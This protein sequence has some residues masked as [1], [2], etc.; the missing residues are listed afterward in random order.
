MCKIC[1]SSS[2]ISN[3]WFCLQALED[4]THLLTFRAHIRISWFSKISE[5]IDIQSVVLCLWHTRGWGW[6]QCNRS[7]VQCMQIHVFHTRPLLSPHRPYCF[8]LWTSPKP[9]LLPPLSYSSTAHLFSKSIPF[10]KEKGVPGNTS[11]ENMEKILGSRWC[12]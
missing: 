1:P 5:I 3:V 9:N 11:S 10:W 4:W 12:Q 7:S 6:L 8:H 2:F